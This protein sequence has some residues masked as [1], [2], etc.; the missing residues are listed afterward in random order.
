M[1][2]VGIVIDRIGGTGIGI[3]FNSDVSVDVLGLNVGGANNMEDKEED[4]EEE[5]EVEGAGR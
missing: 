2:G 3:V 5:E 4:G 1:I